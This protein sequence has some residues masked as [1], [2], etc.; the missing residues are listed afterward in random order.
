MKRTRN[1]EAWKVYKQN[2]RSI[3]AR[4]IAESVALSPA[5]KLAKLDA[6]LGVNVGARRERARLVEQ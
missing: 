4:I 2:Q 5:E 6:R 3:T 1:I